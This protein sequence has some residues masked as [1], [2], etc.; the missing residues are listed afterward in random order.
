MAIR[1]HL[2]RIK[3]I[4][5]KTNRSE[6]KKS[7]NPQ[8]QPATQKQQKNQEFIMR[9]VFKLIKFNISSLSFFVA[10]VA[11][12]GT[13][14]QAEIA[15]ESLRATEQAFKTDERAWLEIKSADPQ[16]QTPSAAFPKFFKYQIY[17]QNVGKTVA[18]DVVAKIYNPEGG[19]DILDNPKSIE[20]MQNTS[21]RFPTN[22]WTPGSIAPNMAT[23]LPLIT[24]GNAPT[25]F[26]TGH[27]RYSYIIGRIDYIDAF[28]MRHWLRFCYFVSNDSGE[29]RYCKS[30]NYE[31]TNSKLN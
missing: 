9:S 24:A 31:D 26:N 20:I 15:R 10:V 2:K 6:S 28:N 21:D 8:S 13:A 3:F 1:K 23:T 5:E 4:P 17:I 18:R 7:R 16:Q 11:A 29:L 27:W 12:V 30:G 19:D 25:L 14:W 22:S